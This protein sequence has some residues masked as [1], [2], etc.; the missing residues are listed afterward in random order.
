[1][2]KGKLIA[3]I[4]LFGS[5]WGLVE[6]SIGDYLHEIDFY[7][8]SIMTGLFGLGFMATTRVLYKQRGMQMGMAL[9]A[10]LL[11]YFHPVGGCLICS[12]IAIIC[13]GMIFEFIWYHSAIMPQKIHDIR[14]KISIGIV[15]GYLLYVFGYISTQ[16]LTPLTAMTIPNVTD[17]IGVLPQTLS[18]GTI[19][20]LLGG[21][22]LPA[23]FSL[24]TKSSYVAKVR[25][26][27]YYPIASLITFL[28]LLYI[29]L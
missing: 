10:G 3:G 4:I 5:I 7:S 25:K 17:I 6:S 19:S 28:S 2:E 15:S 9:V 26:S 1:M 24:T 18:D 12:A 13:E 14:T 8:G 29:V 20:A 22:T 21:A 11:R 27:I 16:L 23:I